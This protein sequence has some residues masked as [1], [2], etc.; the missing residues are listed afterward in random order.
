MCNAIC[1]IIAIVSL[2]TLVVPSARALGG[3]AP[4][5]DENRIR[6][7]FIFNVTLFVE[8]PA[9]ALT[10]STF[11]IAVAGDDRLA[12]ALD[13]GVRGKR[14][15]GRELNVKRLEPTEESCGCQLLFV[16][17][18]D[19]RRSSELLRAVNGKPVLTVGETPAFLRDGGALH[20]YTEDDHL[21]FHINLQNA[22]RAGLRVGSQLLRLATR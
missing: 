8:W 11:V 13:E 19:G 20:F 1:R 2:M 16:S 14:W 7:A 15:R 5:F 18:S 10:G 4:H 6:A 21:R 9:N 22:E 17:S 12:T 3:A